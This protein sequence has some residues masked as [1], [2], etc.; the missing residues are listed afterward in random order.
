MAGLITKILNRLAGKPDYAQ[1]AQDV[2]QRRLNYNPFTIS[3]QNAQSWNTETH[4]DGRGPSYLVETIDY[5]EESGYLDVGYRDGFKARYKNI[6]P[7]LAKQFNAADSKG[8]FAQQHLFNLPYE[9][10]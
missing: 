3:N 6:D 9:A 2:Q 10:I 5:D 4:P 8:R 1:M 7:G